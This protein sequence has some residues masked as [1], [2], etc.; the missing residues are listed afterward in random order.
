[1]TR[2]NGLRIETA[3][4]LGHVP[5]AEA[6]GVYEKPGLDLR[7][8]VSAGA[9]RDRRAAKGAAGYGRA[10][11]HRDAI[12]LGVPL[13]GKHESM[14]IDDAGHVG[15]E[16]TRR[17]DMRLQLFQALR[18]DQLQVLDAVCERPLV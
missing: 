6:G 16:R 15:Q 14:R 2:R 7:G 5:R 13:I 11:L 12:R 18:I 4:F 17:V 10:Q 3:Q 9:D 8:V 1:M